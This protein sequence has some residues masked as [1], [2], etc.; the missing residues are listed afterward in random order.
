MTIELTLKKNNLQVQV[1]LRSMPMLADVLVLCLFIFF[2]FGI[3]GLCA[4]RDWHS[5]CVCACAC[6]R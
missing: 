6:A 2:V 1:L 3:L 4:H 5:M